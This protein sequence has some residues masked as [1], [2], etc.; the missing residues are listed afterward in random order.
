MVNIRLR[1]QILDLSDG[2]SAAAFWLKWSGGRDDHFADDAISN[3]PCSGKGKRTPGD[4]A[5]DE[6]SP[7]T[8]ARHKAGL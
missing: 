1:R 7:Q 5:C 6:A 8:K 2:F 4:H 3:D